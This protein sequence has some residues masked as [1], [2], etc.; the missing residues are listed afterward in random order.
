MLR[1]LAQFLGYEADD[2]LQRMRALLEG[3]PP[4]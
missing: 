1:N 2:Y 3:M 4:V